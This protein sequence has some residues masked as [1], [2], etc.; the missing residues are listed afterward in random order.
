MK[1]IGAMAE[2]NYIGLVLH[3]NA[4]PLGT[5]ASMHSALTI[6]NVVMLEA[7]WINSDPVAE[8]NIVSPFPRVENGYAFPL[9]GAGLG[10]EL[11][12]QIAQETAFRPG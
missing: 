8:S 11:N 2:T 4:G 12:E 9:E 3:N 7:P 1:K 10:I 5:A 6:A